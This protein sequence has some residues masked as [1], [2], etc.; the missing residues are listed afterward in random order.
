MFH[1]LKNNFEQHDSGSL[2][3][4]KNNFINIKYLLNLSF[5]YSA[6]KKII[7]G[8]K[9]ARKYVK[10]FLKINT[11][12]HVLDIGCGNGDII[13][14]LPLGIFY[15]GIDINSNYIKNAKKKFIGKGVFI[16][17]KFSKDLIEN[18]NNFDVIMANGLLHHLGNEDA[19]ELFEASYKALKKG[20]KLITMDGCYIENN[21]KI[22]NLILKSDRGKFVR[23]KECYF[24][25][26]SQTFKQIKIFIRKDLLFIPYCH[27]I[28]ECIK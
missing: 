20:G 26:A 4:M 16:N 8:N 7:G 15:I 25:L 14:F 17:N 21:S 18:Y 9:S 19:I 2:K 22:V 1:F 6:F 5:F 10:E 11:G 23:T 13:N 28:M 3:L 24:K 12:D 27:I